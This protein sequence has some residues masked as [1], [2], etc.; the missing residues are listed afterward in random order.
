MKPLPESAVAE[1]SHVAHDLVV[2]SSSPTLRRV[3]RR[4]LD[5]ISL[6]VPKAF[7][8]SL[9]QLLIRHYGRRRVATDYK[10]FLE[11]ECDGGA[12]IAVPASAVAI[13]GHFPA[14]RY[15]GLPALRR[16]TFLREPVARAISHYFFW[17]NEPRHGNPAH[18]RVLDEKLGLLD[19]ARLPQIRWFY[20]RTIFGGADLSGFDL[21]GVVE[22]LDRDWPIFRK[23]TGIRADLP[24]LNPNRHPAYAE[25]ASRIAADTDAMAMLRHLL[26]EDIEFYRRFL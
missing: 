23:L 18:D 7:G 15:M 8:T 3:P 26:D 12:K 5:L 13:H 17:L 14:T 6:H 25:E 20:T 16:V 21:I 4:P 10:T 22:R 11:A 1:M 19:F 24:H 2:A 9:R